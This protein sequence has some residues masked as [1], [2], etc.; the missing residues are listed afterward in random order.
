MPDGTPED[1]APSTVAPTS[2]SATSLPVKPEKTGGPAKAA[3]KHYDLRQRVLSAIYAVPGHFDTTLNIEGVLATD[4][5]TLNTTLGASIE[6]SV[7]DCLNSL[8]EVWDPQNAYSGYRFVRQSQTFPDV[9]LATDDPS[10]DASEK[11]ILGVELKGWFT[12]AK[13]G[14]PSFRYKQSPKVCAPQDLLVV[15]PWMFRNVVSGAPVLLRPIVTEARFAAEMRNYWWEFVRDAKEPADKR[16]LVAAPHEGFYPNKSNKSN[17]KPISDSGNNFGRI[18]RVGAFDEEVDATMGH[19][20]AG[21]P[22][23][24]W[25]SFLSMFTDSATPETVEREV[26]KLQATLDARFHLSKE[27]NEEL[28][29]AFTQ[30]AVAIAVEAAAPAGKPKKSKA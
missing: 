10:V 2:T 8:R 27:Q 16:G 24:Y 23:K 1:A 28:S 21:I 9:L 11:I 19:L 18:A 30:L 4:L 6:Q 13:E 3:W 22:L 14:E 12:L 25:H 29:K 26:R 17:D 5:F 7:V 15:V 20:A